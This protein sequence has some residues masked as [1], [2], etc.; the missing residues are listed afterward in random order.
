MNLLNLAPEIQE[1]LFFLQETTS[2]RE[3]V[4]EREL[5]VTLTEYSM[6]FVIDGVAIHV[7]RNILSHLA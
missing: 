6:I 3:A 5:R 4:M 7:N 1:R 2:G